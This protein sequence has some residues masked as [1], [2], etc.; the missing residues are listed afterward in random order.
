MLARLSRCFALMLLAGLVASVFL[1]AQA[2]ADA[3]QFTTLDS[4]VVVPN[5]YN[6][7]ARHLGPPGNLE[8]YDRIRFANLPAP[9]TIKIY[10]SAGNLVATLDHISTSGHYLWDGRNDDNQYVVSDVYIYVIE[11]EEYGRKIGK[12]VIIR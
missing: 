3:S 6:V 7:S 5:P 1:P 8:A 10:T 4:V 2:S 9:A 12:L 11:H